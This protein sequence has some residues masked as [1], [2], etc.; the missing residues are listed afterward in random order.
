MGGSQY[1]GLKPCLMNLVVA[2]GALCV[3][4]ALVVDA[5]AQC[6]SAS[7]C[8]DGKF[9][10]TDDCILFVC[11]HLARNCDD[12]DQCTEDTCSESANRCAHRPRIAERCEDFNVTT[13]SEACHLLCD[14]TLSCFD[15]T[16]HPNPCGCDEECPSGTVC[17]LGQCV[18]PT[19]PPSATPTR[20][21]AQTR[22]ATPT[23]ARATATRT[24]T[25]TPTRTATPPPPTGSA[26][27]AP[28]PTDTPESA[29]S[30]S[31]DCDNGGTVSINELVLGVNIALDGAPLDAC[32]AFDQ[33][34]SGRVEINELVAATKNALEGCDADR[35]P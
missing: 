12:G 3:L 28:S 32:P 1:I 21:R 26:T 27:Q 5:G 20:T 9:C 13:L 2:V 16:V 6:L 19:A 34:G 25:R 22:T 17:H 18:A 10:T 11:I 31:G 33:N 4:P 15:D 23:R 29:E 35:L 14:G 30:C 7:D 24:A 8:D